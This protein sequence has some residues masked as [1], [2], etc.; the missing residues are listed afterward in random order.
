MSQGLRPTIYGDGNQTR[1]FTYVA[2]AVAANL[3]ALRHPQ[4]LGGAVYN[5]GTGRRTSLLDLVA[6]INSN[7]G[8]NLGP[9][10]RPVRA[11][12]IRDSQASLDRIQQ[13][14]NYQPIVDFKEGLKR[15]LES[16]EPNETMS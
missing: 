11:G 2:N 4:P 15:T 3:A 13:V 10:F 16:L 12:D 5:V 8:T 6:A 14:L 1:D 9:E 7:L